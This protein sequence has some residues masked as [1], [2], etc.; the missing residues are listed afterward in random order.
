MCVVQLG[1]LYLRYVVNP[2]QIWDWLQYYIEDREVNAPAPHR[3]TA[4]LLPLAV[5]KGAH[6]YTCT[7]TCF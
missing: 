1:F 7:S 2:R 5:H 3:G 4:L 6:T